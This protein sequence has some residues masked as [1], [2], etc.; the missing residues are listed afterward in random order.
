LFVRF[1]TNE[2]AIDFAK[3]LLKRAEAARET[4][5]ELGLTKKLTDF[6]DDEEASIYAYD[7]DKL[8]S[9]SFLDE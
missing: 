7:W 2:D 5:I 3:M 4:H 1:K 8:Q 6:P 9:G